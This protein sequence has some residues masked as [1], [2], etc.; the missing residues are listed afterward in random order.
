MLV[1]A[2]Y[3]PIN[4]EKVVTG[5]DD[6]FARL[7]K[8]GV[9]AAEIEKATD[10]Y[11]Y[12]QQQMRTSDMILAIQLSENLFVDRTMQFQ[13]DQEQKIRTLTP[14]AVNA[15]LRKYI[16]PKRLSIVTAGDFHKKEKDQDKK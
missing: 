3:N 7:L 15:A 9:T 1:L 6:E 16:D 2:I 10:G 8:D 14:D 12:Q 11:L 4:V 5:V 13:A